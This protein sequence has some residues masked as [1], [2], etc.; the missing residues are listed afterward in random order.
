M[1]LDPIDT[2]DEAI[3][4]TDAE[5]AAY[6][7][8]VHEPTIEQRD[9]GW[10]ARFVTWQ[11]QHAALDRWEVDVDESGRIDAHRERIADGVGD[12]AWID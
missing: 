1:G 4:V 9:S 2:I 12:E 6:G 7:D 8:E 11:H 3:G 5:A 10:R